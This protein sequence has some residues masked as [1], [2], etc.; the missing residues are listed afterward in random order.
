MLLFRYLLFAVVVNRVHDV[1]ETLIYDLAIASHHCYWFP[2]AQ[3]HQNHI[4]RALEV[5]V[6]D[7]ANFHSKIFWA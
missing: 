6:Q 4:I 7:W 3:G 1:I 2:T 5:V